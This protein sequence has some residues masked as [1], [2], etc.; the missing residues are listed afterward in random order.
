MIL[1]LTPSRLRQMEVGFDIIEP[2]CKE[3]PVGRPLTRPLRVLRHTMIPPP[4]RRVAPGSSSQSL[5]SEPLHASEGHSNQRQQRHEQTAT[6]EHPL[7]P[8]LFGDGTGFPSSLLLSQT[9]SSR[10][11]DSGANRLRT[12]RPMPPPPPRPTAK[13]KALQSNPATKT[14]FHLIRS[15]QSGRR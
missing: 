2:G 5:S 15:V 11:G 9:T 1:E 7:L 3:I 12:D 10:T 13:M 8:K 14:R 6:I 4:S